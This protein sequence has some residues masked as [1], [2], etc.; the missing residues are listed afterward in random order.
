M[1]NAAMHVGQLAR[2]RCGFQIL[3]GTQAGLEQRSST[4][5]GNLCRLAFRIVVGLCLIARLLTGTLCVPHRR[6]VRLSG[7]DDHVGGTSASP[8]AGIEPA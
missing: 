5:E 3:P 1:T 8:L 2:T 7:H 6:R 4:A